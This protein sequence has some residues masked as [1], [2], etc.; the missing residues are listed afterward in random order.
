MLPPADLEFM[1]YRTVL[2]LLA[3]LLAAVPARALPPTPEALA[4][5]TTEAERRLLTF[6]PFATDPP[7]ELRSRIAPLLAAGNTVTLRMVVVLADFSDRPASGASFD[8]AD[9]ADRLFSRGTRPGGSMAD[10]YIENSGGRLVLDGVVRGWYRMPRRYD[11]YVGGQAGLGFYPFNAQ[12]LVRDAVMAADPDLNYAHFDNDGPDG[13]ADTI[14][15]DRNVDL[16]MVVHTGTGTEGSS[17]PFE[18]RAIAWHIPE[19][20]HVDGVRAQVFALCP[21]GGALG[22]FAHETGHLLGLPDLYDLTGSS[23]GLGTWSLMAGGWSLD[24]GHTPAHLDAWSKARLGI[25][26]VVN[27]VGTLEDRVVDPVNTGGSIYRLSPGGPGAFEYF[28]VENRQPVG[29]DRFLPGGGFL[30]YHVDELRPTNNIRTNYKVA[31]EQPDGLYGLENLLSMP[32]FGDTGDVYTGSTPSGGFGRF[33]TPDSRT[34]AGT[35]TGVAL[36]RISGPDEEGRM[37]GSFRI[38]RGP[39]A[40]LGA[41]DVTVVEGD[42]D[43]FFE[44]GEVIEIRPEIRVEGG[45]VTGVVIRALSENPR[46]LLEN[47]RVEPGTLAAGSHR[48]AVA[49]R[50]R[51]SDDLPSNPYGLPI[52]LRVDFREEVPAQATLTIGAGDAEGFATDFQSDPAGFRSRRLRVSRYDVWRYELSGGVGG[53]RAF[54]AG[55][56]TGGFRN[57]ADAALES[58]LILLPDGAR[59]KLDQIV[60]IAPDDSGRVVAGGF[61]EISVNGGAW[62]QIEPTRG[63]DIRYFSSDPLISGREIFT[64]IDPNWESIE[65]DLSGFQGS[66]LLRF[67]FFSTSSRFTGL[68]WWIDNVRVESSST[69]VRLLE[70]SAAREADAVRL[71]W[72]LDPDD[73]PAAVEV[74]RA[75]EAPG[76]WLALARLPGA[77]TGEYRDTAPPA[78]AAT[79]RLRATTREGDTREL[80]RIVA[81]AGAASRVP[82]RL[83]V[84]PNPVAREAVLSFALER[85]EPVRIVLFDAQG[86]RRAVLVDDV[87]DAG[88]HRVAWDGRGA[89]GARLPGGLYFAR[90][91]TPRASRTARVVVL[92]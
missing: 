70:L 19:A 25:A 21:F 40:R 56:A 46:L 65:F 88:E 34:Y 15:D 54:H 69:P 30:V 80:G 8:P 4:A 59:L 18:L 14:D 3:A 83:A 79:Y 36:Y 68:G 58:P 24:G 66:A 23:F 44:A 72:R 28:L 51:L 64:G 55:N 75:G 84:D 35:E 67:R 37:T 60:D 9:L 41:V 71:A 85:T 20:V 87:R 31:L 52:D 10:Y 39:V 48:D 91:E 43:R 1:S 2:P 82:L 32:S 17:T 27:V 16:L 78:G 42:G 73:L 33:T 12:G 61:V 38:S 11:A 29:F 47:D 62:Q 26:P 50:G 7:E 90:I 74:A 89:G 45:T 63:Y 86:R 81:A 22:V 77:A 13:V 6:E 53:G 5:A 49:F 57:D 92:P 76:E